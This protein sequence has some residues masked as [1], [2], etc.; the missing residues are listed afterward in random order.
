MLSY[1]GVT[2]STVDSFY[3]RTLGNLPYQGVFPST[4]SYYQ[5]FHNNLFP[6]VQGC[7]G[8]GQG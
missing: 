1:A 2:G 4:A 5:N 6:R 7:A 8:R 3:L